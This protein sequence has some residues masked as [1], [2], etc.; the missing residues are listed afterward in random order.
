M[1]RGFGEVE[2]VQRLVPEWLFP[3]AEAMTRL[4]D[5]SVLVGVTV[6]G[7]LVLERERGIALLGVVIGGGAILAGLKAILALGRPPSELHLIETATTG[8]PSGHAL[9][10]AVVYGALALSLEGGRQRRRL[11][12]AGVLVVAISFSRVVLGVHY[13]V[14]IV[15]GLTVAIGYLWAMERFARHSPGRTLAVAATLGLLA[16][17]AGIAFG[18]TPRTVC[19]EAVCADR[20]TAVTGAAGV[21]AAVAWGVTNRI[22]RNR[23]ATAVVLVPATLVGASTLALTD[24]VLLVESIGAGVGAAV[25]VLLAG[26]ATRAQ[27]RH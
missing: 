14:D 17:A 13:L 2:A 27:G 12:L 18:P 10:A 15:A 5:L 11:A 24:S 21:G 20:E 3:A 16:V 7:T 22:R 19:L 4:G 26:R 25:L 23:T 9:G 6:V 1:D 8:F